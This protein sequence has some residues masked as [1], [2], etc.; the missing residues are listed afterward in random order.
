MAELVAMPSLGMTMEEGT[1]VEW[2]LGVGAPVEKGQLI[3]II[4]SEKTEVE[5]EAPATGFLRHIYVEEGDT[6]PCGT[7]LAAITES[8][9]EAFDAAAFQAANAP[10]ETET[11]APLKVKTDLPSMTPPTPTDSG[12]PK[13][14]PIAPAARATAGRLGI[15]SQ[16]V[17][18][19]GPNGRVTKQDVEAHARVREA[20]VPVASGVA[21]E[22]PTMGTGDPIVLLPGLG[23]DASAFTR[24][25]PVLAEHARVIAVNPRGVGLS[26]AP[27]AEMYPISQMATDAA[28]TWEGSADLIGASL[29]AAT[30]LE[31]A[32]SQPERVRSLTLITPFLEA[33]PRLLAVARGWQRVAAE[34]TA[35]TL[36]AS[37]L[38]WFFSSDFLADDTVRDRTLR[39]LVQTISRVPASTLNRMVAG[40]STWDGLRAD[41]LSS[42]SVP[43]LVIVAGADL[44][45]P[46]A[47]SVAA[48]LPN[49]DLLVVPGAGHAVALEAPDRVNQAI[50]AHLARRS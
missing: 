49:A 22:V 26:D 28:A 23:T 20:L 17:T 6:V 11:V 42:I 27:L 7:V 46:D 2:P 12:P 5:I 48:A 19:T 39:G 50:L 41:I 24:Q 45:V 10:T 35:E 3:L 29:G 21:L 1:V 13:R 37:L 43:I 25:T 18:G 4:E 40:L 31:L 9:D 38:P 16:T 15:D 34:A 30:A 36:A 8:A 33:T 14:K 44:L 32:C 47:E